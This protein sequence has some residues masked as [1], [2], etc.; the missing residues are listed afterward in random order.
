MERTL[1]VGP[2]CIDGSLCGARCAH[3]GQ[4][5][6]YDPSSWRGPLAPRFTAAD[7][8]GRE[9]SFSSSTSP[10]GA[11][12]A[13][14][15]CV[16]VRAPVRTSACSRT[17]LL[18]G[19]AS[20][21]RFACAPRLFPHL[22]ASPF[23]GHAASPSLRQVPRGSV[24]PSTGCSLRA[25]HCLRLRRLYRRGHLRRIPHFR[26]RGYPPCP[27]WCRCVTIPAPME[28]GARR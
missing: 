1:R 13:R 28:K 6:F 17:H 3:H 7:G 22:R 8:G 26:C 21:V 12:N 16:R 23:L 9:S 20:F 25:A 11:C 2:G 4:P 27:A 18:F 10:A 14:P 24:D 5:F 15:A 19:A